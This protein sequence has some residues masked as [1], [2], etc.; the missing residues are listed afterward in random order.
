MI[1]PLALLC[2]SVQVQV[3]KTVG[4]KKRNYNKEDYCYYCSKRFLSKISRHFLAMHTDRAAVQ[5][6]VKSE[7]KNREDLLYR[8]QQLGNYKHNTEVSYMFSFIV[9]L[10]L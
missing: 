2:F 10:A 4:D 3:Y 6:I 8:L 1:I 7:G 5:E 9:Y